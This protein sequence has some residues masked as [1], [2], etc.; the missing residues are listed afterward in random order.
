VR[1]P[2]VAVS[3]TV[4]LQEHRG[5]QTSVSCHVQGPGSTDANPGPLPISRMK[6]HKENIKKG[7]AV[8]ALPNDNQSTNVHC[9][10]TILPHFNSLL[11]LAGAHEVALVVQG[12][13]HLSKVP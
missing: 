5:T 7:A 6:C 9:L 10:E 13:V 8:L 3:T 12:L 4:G 11:T 1:T 2:W